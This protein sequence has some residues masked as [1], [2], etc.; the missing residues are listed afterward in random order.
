MIVVASP[1]DRSRRQD[2]VANGVFARAVGGSAW[3]M[4]RRTIFHK[5]GSRIVRWL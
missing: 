5:P 4:G 3:I 1:Y 2:P